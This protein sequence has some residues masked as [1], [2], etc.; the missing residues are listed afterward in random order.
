[1]LIMLVFAILI[2]IEILTFIVLKEH[3]YY[4]SRPKFF[5]ILTANLILSFMLWFLLIKIT[6]F[7]GFYDE[8]GN[9]AAHL[10]LTGMMCA[11]VVPRILLSFLHY[12]GKL[13]HLRKGSHSLWLTNAGIIV[14]SFIFVIIALGSLV[15][16]YNFKTEKVTV[17]IK[18]LDPELSGLKIVQ[19]SDMHLVSFYHHH[20]MLKDLMEKVN[21]FNPDIIINTGDFMSFGWREFD[22]CDTILSGA[23]SRYGNFAV[24]GNHD[25]GTYFPNS[26][27]SD[28]LDITLKL[29][30]LITASGYR[31]L[32]NEYIILNIKGARIA[33]IGVITEGRYPEIIHGDLNKAMQGLDSVD[34][35]ILLAHDPNQWKQDVTGKTDISL[36]LSGHTHGMQMGILTKRFKWS[37]SQYIYPQWNGLYKEAE[38]YLYVNRGLGILAI[39]FRIWMP[40]EIT[41]LTLVSE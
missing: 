36:T 5:I 21:S 20:A 12:S 13:L 17:R 27:E 9:I 24:A 6:A 3:Y 11:V 39:P 31:M 30:A 25:R 19:L 29:N 4:R 34:L 7:K 28:K 35:K 16:R 41:V 32:N 10:Y 33:L 15:G 38:Q 22:R 18:E 26:T 14:S 37:P 8:P 1:M 2:V 40:P 23:K